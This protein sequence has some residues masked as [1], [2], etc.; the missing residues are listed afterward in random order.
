MELRITEI[1]KTT[2]D[3]PFADVADP[4]LRRELPLWSFSEV[5]RVRT[6]V[7][8]TGVGETII[9]YTWGRVP[10]RALSEVIGKN[11]F[12]LLYRDDL[13]AGL[14][15]AL[16]D[17]AAQYAGVPVHALMGEK[18]REQVP[19][20]WW[21][22]DMSAEDW[23][24]QARTAVAVGYTDM[25]LK[26]RPWWDIVQNVAAVC[27][28]VGKAVHIDIDFNGF[29]ADAQTARTVCKALEKHSNVVIFETPIPQADVDG[30]ARLR[31]HIRSNIAHHFGDPSTAEAVREGI[32]D[33]FVIGGSAGTVLS[34]GHA[35]AKL[36]MPFWLQIVGTGITTTWANHLGA[37]LSHATWPA[38]TCLNIYSHQLITDPI[39]VSNGTVRVSDAPGLGIQ[40]D[41]EAV[42]RFE[43]TPPFEKQRPRELYGIHFDD[44]LTVYYRDPAYH[45]DFYDRKLPV[46]HRNVRL[47]TWM[48]DGS[49]EFARVYAE[50]AKGP[51]RTRP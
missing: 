8:L 30:N 27:A 7:G 23:A 31:Y 36:D 6:N 24:Q 44:G 51:V 14:Q 37:V 50:T 38:I 46:T 12:E 19:I 45:Q 35:A 29:L 42:A 17:L 4:H 11:P 1:E 20:G 34:Q 40:L 18:L 21:C 32:C 43:A 25:K 16:W 5:L 33:G 47:Q 41:E 49:D 26:A 22:I 28:A 10:D 48:E 3:V 2:V 13:G 9:Y 39:H 15:M